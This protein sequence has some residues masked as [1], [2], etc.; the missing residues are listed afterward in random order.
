M[1]LVLITLVFGDQSTDEM[2]LPVTRDDLLEAIERVSASVNPSEIERHV[3]W[4]TEFG[5]S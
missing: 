4:M 3:K 5:S 1:L 2:D